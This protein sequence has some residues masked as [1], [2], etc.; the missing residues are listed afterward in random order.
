MTKRL[1]A[2]ALC[3]GMA[4]AQTKTDTKAPAASASAVSDELKQIE[5]D[6]S[7]ALKAKDTARL[8]EIV[9]DGWSEL[10]SSGKTIT[11]AKLLADMKA[12]GNT[13]DSIEMGPMNVRV[14][15]NTAI[16]TGSDIEKSTDSGKDTS[17][18]YIWTDVFVKQN[19]KWRAVA[20]QN[21][22]VPK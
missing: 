1:M 13:L 10:D 19:G 11:K 21:T 4:F 22:K 7:A 16:V 6:W 8:A 20:S 12:P 18:K 5:M 2:I 15:G 9:A 14:F 17:G 3:A